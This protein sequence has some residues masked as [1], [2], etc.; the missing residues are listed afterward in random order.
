MLLSSLVLALILFMRFGPDIPSR[1]NLN[2]LLV[3]RPLLWLS[4][5]ERHDYLFLILVCVLLLGG[6]EILLMMGPEF[7][8]GY[9]ADLAI[10][11]DI[12]AATYLISAV[13]YVKAV[14]KA[15]HT[16]LSGWRSS[17]MQLCRAPRERVARKRARPTCAD[18]D[19]DHSRSPIFRLAA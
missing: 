17:V 3:D 4:K 12:I 16:Q 15:V 6:G 1:R 8:I 13:T 11:L 2:E 19:D 18:N 10:Y 5:Q 7:V 14:V 9:A